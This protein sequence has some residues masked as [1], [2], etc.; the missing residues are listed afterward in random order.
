M[1]FL[2]DEHRDSFFEAIELTGSAREDGTISAYFGASLYLLAA[3]PYAYPRMRRFLS[4]D[5]I[6]FPAILE[7]VVLSSG[8]AVIV[9]LAG[10]LYNGGFFDQYTPL[11]IVSSC[12]G[13]MVGLA[14][15]ALLLRKER[16]CISGFC[17]KNA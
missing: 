7:S 9:S 3:L 10:N 1:K 12:D 13:E 17:P 5:C 11:D 14:C 4:R 16:L 2:N 15:S 8:E 6:D